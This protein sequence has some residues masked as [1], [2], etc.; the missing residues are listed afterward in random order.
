MADMKRVYKLFDP[1]PLGDDRADLY[2]NLDSV[3]GSAGLVRRMAQKIRL[4][5]P[6]TCQVIAGHRGSGKSTELWR[7]G[8]ELTHPEDAKD[9]TYAVVTLRA[10]DVLDP[11]DVD[12]P[13]LI[14]A[15][16]QQ[17]A[18]TLGG[19]PYRIKLRPGYFQELLPRLKKALG[20]EVEITGGDLVTPLGRIGVAVKNSP[21]ARSEVRK[22]LEPHTG[23]LLQAANDFFGEAALAVEKEGKAG[24]VVIVD[25][26]DKMITRPHTEAGCP[27]TEYLFVHR[28]AQLTGLACHMVYSIPI[29]LAYSCHEPTIRQR[30]GGVIHMVPMTKVTTP[31]P[32]RAPYE[33]GITLL[34]DL[35]GKRAEAAG[36]ALDDLFQDGTLRE[37]ILF[38]GGQPSELMTMIREA[39]IADGLPIG[40]AGL[41]RCITE[42]ERGYA[43]LLMEEHKPL[44][45][46]AAETG[47]VTR[48]NETEPLL[49]DLLQ[50][51]TVLLY[52][53]DDEWYDVN[54]AAR[55][56]V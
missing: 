40:Q 6:P 43:R 54:P 15:I 14:L 19:A 53:N 21:D 36:A 17:V 9:S 18:A 34:T 24:L 12:V 10:L 2:V 51:R 5:D 23:T 7:L 50:N 37:M 31:P 33:E 30:Y 55:G 4:S 44:L 26:L 27:T 46:E 22:A 8:R 16:V 25:D 56:V 45:K 48:S 28:S 20:T 35:V 32:D 39:M 38:S 47:N 42:S 1:A 11:N 49:R 52:M 13:E 3:R 29:E 41:R